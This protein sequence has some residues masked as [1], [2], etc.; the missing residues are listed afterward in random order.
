M[1]GYVCPGCGEVFLYKDYDE[2]AHA[3]KAASEH[4][5]EEHNTHNNV[6]GLRDRKS[7]YKQPPEWRYLRD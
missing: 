3:L 7:E 1:I 5:D 2:N 6:V 4:V